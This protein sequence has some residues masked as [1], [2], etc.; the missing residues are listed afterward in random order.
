DDLAATVEED[1]VLVALVV[2]AVDIGVLGVGHGIALVR[3]VVRPTAE[4]APTAEIVAPMTGKTHE[5]RPIGGSSHGPCAVPGG[6][7]EELRFLEHDRAV[8][9]PKL[10]GS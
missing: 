8:A 7:T 2:V 3:R 5:L 9:H 10:A 4:D 6:G 1:P